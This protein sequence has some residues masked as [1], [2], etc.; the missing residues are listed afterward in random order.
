MAADYE[1]ALCGYPQEKKACR[2]PEGKSPDFCPMTGGQQ[3]IAAA[4]EIYQD[5]AVRE[6]ARLASI[7]EAEGYGD[8]QRVP[9]VKRPIKTRIEE[10]WE[11]AHRTG[12]TRIG[13]AFCGGLAAE[14]R[15]V[16]EIFSAHDLEVVSVVCKVGGVPKETIGITDAEKIRPGTRETMCNPIAQAQL[17][18]DAGTQ[19]NVL[20]GL[21][22][23]HDSLL[24]KHSDAPCTVLAVKDRVTG[25]NPLAA[26]YNSR[27]YYERLRRG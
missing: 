5:P 12:C 23:G 10:T 21:C 3:E 16:S 19:L 18:N 26:V 25:H 20:L 7:Q 27:S 22:V 1:C 9:F 4:L 24:M 6:F 15:L 13:L 8:R 14:A 11:F 2:V 17:L